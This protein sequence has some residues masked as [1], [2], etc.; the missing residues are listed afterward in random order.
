MLRFLKT[1]T[2]EGVW[3]GIQVYVV[4]VAFLTL[5]FSAIK[6]IYKNLLEGETFDRFRAEISM[7]KRFRHV[8]C[9]LVQTNLSAAKYHF[10]FGNVH[11]QQRS[12]YCDRIH[13]RGEP[14]ASK[15]HTS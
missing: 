14:V 3:K 4:V 10:I 1:Y 13:A 9:E 7:L 11:R 6:K 12:V 2:Q 8:Q 5:E 15:R